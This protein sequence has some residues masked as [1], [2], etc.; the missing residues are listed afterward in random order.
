MAAGDRRSVRALPVL[1]AG[2]LLTAACG[3]DTR[4]EPGDC[5]SSSGAAAADAATR[6]TSTDDPSA[7][8]SY[9][10]QERMDSAKPAPMPT[11]EGDRPACPS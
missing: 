9:W 2:L 10:T 3:Q 7:V 4:G 8:A 11:K 1:L 5:P 6:H